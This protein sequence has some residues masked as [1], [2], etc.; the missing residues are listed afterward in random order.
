MANLFVICRPI[1]ASFILIIAIQSNATADFTIPDE[2][3]QKIDAILAMPAKV[4]KIDDEAEQKMLRN[5]DDFF[6]QYIDSRNAEAIIDSN[7]SYETL[8]QELITNKPISIY[9]G[10]TQALKP[11]E[12]VIIWY[13]KEPKKRRFFKRLEIGST[14]KLTDDEIKRLSRYFIQREKLCK[15]TSF[16][17]FKVA[18]VTT[19]VRRE[20]DAGNVAGK[21]HYLRQRAIIVRE[22]FGLEV[23]NSRQIIELHPESKELLAYK[24]IQWS[25]I[26]LS[27]GMD[28]PLLTRNEVLQE[29]KAA[30]DFP[31]SDQ[32]IETVYPVYF[33]T[34]Q[35]AVPCIAVFP[36]IRNDQ[37]EPLQV[38]V[39]SIIQGITIDS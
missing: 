20:R 6:N 5:I 34:E 4:Y 27:S 11:D 33:L 38:M 16:D 19:H 32:I 22:L 2:V 26:L 13:T 10:I 24:S 9:S 3:V 31:A 29:I 1:I 12:P 30:Y 35:K 8:R 15:E 17:R 7:G 14:T 28:Y 25:P 23:I 39:F 18:D 21:R 37:T 36:K